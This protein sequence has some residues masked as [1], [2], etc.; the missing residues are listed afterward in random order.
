M[1]T[2]TLANSGDQDEMPH[3]QDEMPHDQ[4]EMSHDVA[5]H[6]GPHCFHR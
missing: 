6:Q 2:G 5:I 4:D 1:Q 3:D